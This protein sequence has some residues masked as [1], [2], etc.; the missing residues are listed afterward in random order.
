MEYGTPAADFDAP[1]C[2]D[3]DGYRLELTC[4]ACPEQYDV[5]KGKHK[6][7]YLRL[8]H[9]SFTA[10][11]PYN[12]DHVYAARTRGD[13]CFDDAEERKQHLTAAVAA[14]R[15]ASRYSGGAQ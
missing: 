8:R 2:F 13:G 4:S 7:G 14:I 12:G 11:Y 5:I 3:I 15:T 10:E 6:V 1:A 9:G